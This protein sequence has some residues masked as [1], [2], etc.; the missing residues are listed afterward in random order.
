VH[1]PTWADRAQP[2]VLRL[3]TRVGRRLDAATSSGWSVTVTGRAALVTDPEAIRRYQAVPLVPRPVHA[4]SSSPS[5]PSWQ[6]AAAS[7][8]PGLL[9]AIRLAAA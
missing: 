4:I 8:G 7:D 6:K 9:T 3:N 1:I 5:P 2:D